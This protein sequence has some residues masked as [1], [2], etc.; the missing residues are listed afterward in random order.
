MAVAGEGGKVTLL[1]VM[2]PHSDIR[3]KN[4][5][6][7]TVPVKPFSAV[8][9]MVDVADL[10]EPALIGGGEL[11]AMLKSVKVNVA[12]ALWATVPLVTVMVTANVT[13]IVELQ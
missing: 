3:P 5:F 10:P 11:A 8:T 12:V 7:V 1:G 2:A 9:V 6:S 13:A 4:G